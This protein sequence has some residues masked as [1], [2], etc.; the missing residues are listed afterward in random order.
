MHL[1]AGVV[2]A[3]PAREGATSGSTSS[4]TG[5][6]VLDLSALPLT[7]GNVL[8]LAF[9]DEADDP[10]TGPS[11]WT[12]V[13]EALAADADNRMSVFRKTVVASEDDSPVFEKQ[14]GSRCAWVCFE[15]S[16]AHGDVEAEVAEG[17]TPPSLS[18]AWGS[19]ATRWVTAASVSA[20][21][22]TL[23]APSGYDGQT[24]GASDSSTADSRK[25]TAMAHREN[26]AASENPDAWGASGTYYQPISAT[27][28]VRPA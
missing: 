5:D 3:F 7:E 8:V 19:A 11:G 15:Y 10:H 22:N 23:T 2:E 13:D 14:G 6:P 27:I 25:R 21:A 20:S 24:D 4:L 16:G 26:E 17:L 12:K 18:P 1:D 28:A 9:R